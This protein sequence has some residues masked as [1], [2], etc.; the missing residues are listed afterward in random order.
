MSDVSKFFSD[1]YDSFIWGRHLMPR[2]IDRLCGLIEKEIPFVYDKENDTDVYHCLI[3]HENFECE[4]CKDILPNCEIFE[5]HVCQH[6]E[7]GYDPML[8]E[9]KLKLAKKIEKMLIKLTSEKMN[10]MN[11]YKKQE[12]TKLTVNEKIEYYLRYILSLMYYDLFIRNYKSEIG[13]SDLTDAAN[14]AM[15]NYGI[16]MISEFEFFKLICD[17]K[18]LNDLVEDCEIDINIKIFEDKLISI[19]DTDKKFNKKIFGSILSIRNL[20]SEN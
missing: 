4:V 3:E 1:K 13:N 19:L 17:E 6:P 20:I 5:F 9:D 18:Y 12:F 15:L 7:D 11:E 2:E 10:Y 14:R 8:S 16:N